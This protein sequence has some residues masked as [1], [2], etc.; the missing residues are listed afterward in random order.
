MTAPSARS[1]VT[2]EE[3]PGEPDLV[4]SLRPQGVLWAG[5]ERGFAGWGEAARLDPGT[6]PQRFERAWAAVRDLFAGMAVADRVGAPGTGPVAFGGFT[7][8]ERDAGSIVVV[9]AE[10]VGRN[11]RTSWRTAIDGGDPAPPPDPPGR[12]DRIR[13]GGSTISEIAWLEAVAEAE[14]TIR[15][16]DLAKVV[17]ARDVRVWSKSAFDLRLLAGRLAAGF[18]ECF[19]FVLGGLVGATPELLVRRIGDVVESVVLA[20]SARRGA[21]PDEDARLGALLL[22]SDKDGREHELAVTSVHDALAPLCRR[23]D[24]V[25]ERRLL[26]LANVQHIATHFRGRLGGDYSA[27]EIA[28]VLHPTA[29]VCGAP[30]D[31]ALEL[32]RSLEGMRRGL[33]GGPVGWVDSRGDGEWGIALRCAEI[34]AAAGRLFAGAGIVAGSNPEAELEE[35]RLKLRAMQSAFEG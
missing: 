23:L 12:S 17:L 14:R 25:A 6:G 10:V 30:R 15:R 9:P 1:R 28:G 8:D 18:P 19:T 34:S 20:G 22:A 33:Y 7:F 29:A 13:Y 21:D 5:P 16:G 31:P 11:G 32:I 26:R 2:T 24:A 27:V 35:T 4:S 3:E